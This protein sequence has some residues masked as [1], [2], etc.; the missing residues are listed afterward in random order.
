[1]ASSIKTTSSSPS[2]PPPSSSTTSPPLRQIPIVCPGH[3]RPIAQV[4]YNQSQ[5]ARDSA[6]NDVPTYLISACH[7][8]L[9]MLRHATSG[10]WYGT[11]EGHKGAVWS[12]ALNDAGTL[13]GTGSADYTAKIWDATDGT[14]LHTF[15]DATHMLKSVTLTASSFITG[16]HDATVRL[17]DLNAYDAAPRTFTVASATTKVPLR[18]VLVLSTAQQLWTGDAQGWLRCYELSSGHLL[19]Q[20]MVDPAGIRDVE[21]SRDERILSVAAGKHVVFYD[22]T[23]ASRMTD[24]MTPSRSFEMP[25]HFKEEGGVSLHPTLPMFIAGGNDTWVRKF[26]YT[27][28]KE[29]ECHKG[30]HGPVR[31]VRYAPD[32]LSY[33][34]GSEDGTIRIWQN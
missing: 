14:C 29:L 1:M 9:P 15:S 24:A 12:A 32:G 11:F 23:T 3:S 4:A 25:I 5:R 21:V 18:T 30:H 2:P 26:D 13:A 7:D 19:S 17:Y 34:T 22:L 28:G 31:C 27:T 6:T 33:A 20:T 16:G 10:D 8:K